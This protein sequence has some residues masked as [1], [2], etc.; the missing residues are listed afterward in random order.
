MSSI[1]KGSG[2]N[3][4]LRNGTMKFLSYTLGQKI[5]IG[6]LVQEPFEAGRVTVARMF[7]LLGRKKMPFDVIV[8]NECV[9]PI[10]VA[11][12]HFRIKGRAVTFTTLP[13]AVRVCECGKL[14]W[15]NYV[16]VRRVKKKIF[17]EKRWLCQCGKSHIEK[18]M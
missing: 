18:N 4:S 1:L 14:V 2:E 13:F 16:H 17:R 3:A 6:L 8:Y 5:L 7:R 15:P 10:S 9:D 11:E 12:H